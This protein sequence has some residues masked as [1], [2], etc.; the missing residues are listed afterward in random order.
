METK[1][2]QESFL[3][4]LSSM[5]EENYL[6]IAST[7]LG[8]VPMPFNKQS[9]GR[10]ILSF[11]MN[12]ENRRNVVASIAEHE[13]PM[14]RLI[15]VLGSASTGQLEAFCCN[16]NHYML[17]LQLDGLCDRLL[18]FK[19]GTCFSINPIL[20]DDVGGLCLNGNRP[21][22]SR[23]PI[24][25]QNILR[26]V[27]NLLTNGS[28]PQRDANIHHF[29]KSGRLEMVFPQ[30]SHSQRMFELIRHL[31]VQTHAVARKGCHATVDKAAAKMLLSMTPL[32]ICM[33][34]IHTWYGANAPKA[35]EDAMCVLGEFPMDG[36][37]LAMFI[38]ATT[39]IGKPAIMVQDM[40]ALGL[41][42]RNPGCEELSVNEAM[43]DPLVPM[44]GFT[45][46]SNLSVS[47]YGVPDEDDI[48]Y[49]FSDIQKCDSLVEYSITKGSFSRALGMG[50]GREDIECYL[51]D[52]SVHACLEIWEKSCSRVK[53]YDGIAL[54]CSQEVSFLLGN[55]P[56][57][58]SSIVARI[59]DGVFIMKRSN[60][61][62]WKGV[63]SKALDMDDIPIAEEGG[64]A[65]GQPSWF[66]PKHY[67]PPKG[68][69]IANDEPLHGSLD[70]EAIKADLLAYAQEQGC[71]SPELENLVESRR[72][73][74][75]SQ[76]SKAFRYEKPQS[77]GGL[78]FNAKL[79][80]LRKAISK[81][82]GQSV[83]V[84]KLDLLDEEV[85]V[86]PMSL[87]G[88]GSKSML[89]AVVLPSGSERMIPIG[90]IFQVTL[91]RSL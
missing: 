47:Y 11:F 33:A 42:C 80:L 20:E 34:A 79:V 59:S 51:K 68:G 6:R 84:M 10:S 30:F 36:K 24:V 9:V 40:E 49:L 88:S 57:L 50:I 27:M 23:T 18:L 52:P 37:R 78:D 2:K 63:L 62:Q 19:T 22:P 56:E 77:A 44:S 31:V 46:D 54:Q 66:L 7:I 5:E 74:S 53:L 25:D 1:A 28:V 29:Y 67:E 91:V 32:D 35:A 8:K 38:S 89:K 13:K 70:W 43:A 41:V 75:K 60:E 45:I 82:D 15:G 58:S 81:K 4:L 76:I 16:T 86:V 39:E 61:E 21:R 90:T 48:L 14:L 65:D 64:N 85:L 17:M 26:A 71:L 87:Q 72:I 55:I 73:V 12:E 3:N 69:N 83:K